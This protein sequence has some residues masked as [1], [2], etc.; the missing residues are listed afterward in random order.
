[1]RDIPV[2]LAVPRSPSLFFCDLHMLVLGHLLSL[3]SLPC[4]LIW[5]SNTIPDFSLY[6]CLLSYA[7]DSYIQLS[8]QLLYLEDQCASQT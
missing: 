1:M 5:A 4:G 7:P 8:P 3:H 6:T 2:V